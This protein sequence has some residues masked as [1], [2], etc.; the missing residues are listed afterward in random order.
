MAATWIREKNTNGWLQPE[1]RAPLEKGTNHRPKPSNC[2]GSSPEFSGG[3]FVAGWFQ[4]S[5]KL[6]WSEGLNH[7]WMI[8]LKV[9]RPTLIL[10]PWTNEPPKS[11]RQLE[12]LIHLLPAFSE[13]KTNLSF[14][15]KL[16][17]LISIETSQESI[18]P[19]H[20]RLE[21]PPCQASGRKRA[22]SMD[23]QKGSLKLILLLEQ[24]WK[25]PAGGVRWGLVPKLPPSSNHNPGGSVVPMGGSPILASFPI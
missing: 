21:V 16:T 18:H 17:Q 22:W 2:W 25:G 9:C 20:Q 15:G 4:A 11:V 19:T 6:S 23:V 12:G 3:V 24:A 7:H 5:P 14:S 10:K 1:I 8:K 13:K